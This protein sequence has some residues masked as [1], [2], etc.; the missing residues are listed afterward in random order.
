MKTKI[1][2]SILA[3][4]SVLLVMVFPMQ[5]FSADSIFSFTEDLPR[6]QTTTIKITGEGSM[7]LQPDAVFIRLDSRSQPSADL[8]RVVESQ[9]AVVDDLISSLE[10]SSENSDELQI[11][12]TQN[13]R[14]YT[15]QSRI[16]DPSL[17]SYVVDF[18]IPIKIPYSQST[19]LFEDLTQAG[20]SIDNV[21]ITKVSEPSETQEPA[22]SANVSIPSGTSVPSCEETNSCYVP[23]EIVISPGTKVTWTNDDSAA[24]TVTSG[25]PEGGPDGVFDSALF[26]AGESFSHSF[27]QSGNYPYFCMVHPWMIG[28][29][30]VS[31]NAGLDTSVQEYGLVAE[32]D[33]YLQSTPNTFDDTVSAYDDSISML[34]SILE[35]YELDAKSL[36]ERPIRIDERYRGYGEPSYYE[37]RDLIMV[38]TSIDNIENVVDVAIRNNAQIEEIV[39]T[40]LPSTMA[41]IRPELTKLALDDAKTAVLEIIE[42]DGLSIK[43]IKSIEVNTGDLISPQFEG[44]VIHGVGVS[45]DRNYYDLNPLFAKVQ[46]EFEVGH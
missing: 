16:S 18:R 6:T 22:N 7:D 3:A 4:A 12:R 44:I 35:K 14:I 13:G 28:K 36:H 37:S 1:A 42:P 46:V 39:P 30:T 38:R 34:S 40:Y 43:G 17:S 21:R 41:S 2:I 10:N 19:M 15:Q 20:F 31:G 8:T 27:L 5:V 32:F 45:I 11:S 24:H 25:T 9:H 26:T 23:Y 29:I 33:V